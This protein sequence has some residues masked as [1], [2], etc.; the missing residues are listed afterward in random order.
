MGWVYVPGLEDSSSDCISSSMTTE[1]WLSLNQTLTQRPL[2]WRGWR[3]R[4]WIRRLSGTISRPSEANLGVESWIS[5]LRATRASLSASPAQSRAKPTPGISGRMS[6][7]LLAR[8]HPRSLFS[9][10]YR[11]TLPSDLTLFELTYEQWVTLLKQ[12][13]LARRKLARLMNGSASSCWPSARAEDSQSCGNHSGRSV[14]DSLS[15]S[16]TENWLTPRAMELR[17]SAA[18]FVA[19]MGESPETWE[20]RRQGL[21]AKGY[22][23]NGAGT[24]LA[25]AAQLFPTPNSRD[26]KGSS[27][28]RDRTEGQSLDGMVER[29]F[30]PGQTIP[31]A[32]GG[33][34]KSTRV[35]NPRFV[36]M[37]MGWL[38]GWTDSAAPV[39]GFTQYKQLWRSFLF[40]TP[41]SSGLD[42]HESLV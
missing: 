35:L 5:S 40:G 28:D 20:A 31:K 38:V 27:G 33:S 23:G 32:G 17:E 22:N 4:P 6:D 12:G 42:E 24:P 26:W 29:S 19:R 21:I 3:T 18:S 30:H 25:M 8:Y 37:L 9:R 1:V 34:Y 16:A 14:P 13:S 39:T 2:S 7:G 11:T 41:T 36:E 10:T 15:R